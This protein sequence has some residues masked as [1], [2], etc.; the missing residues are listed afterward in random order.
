MGCDQVQRN[1]ENEVI[2]GLL[3]RSLLRNACITQFLFCVRLCTGVIMGEL[4]RWLGIRIESWPR[5]VG[6]SNAVYL[7]VFPPTKF[8]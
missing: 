7:G 6:S 3:H 8:E 2:A 5:E 4:V 1:S